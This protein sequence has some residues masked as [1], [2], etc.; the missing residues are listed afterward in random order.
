MSK[1]EAIATL[2]QAFKHNP[3]FHETMRNYM[4][5]RMMDAIEKHAPKLGAKTAEKV[6]KN[7]SSGI[8]RLFNKIWWEELAM[9]DI[10]D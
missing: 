1:L 2:E 4:E 6:V 9:K 5:L 7:A 8:I 10:K 3:E